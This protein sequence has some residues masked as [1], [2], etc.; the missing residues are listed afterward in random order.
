VIVLDDELGIKWATAGAPIASGWSRDDFR[1]ITSRELVHPDDMDR[2]VEAVG[3]WRNHQ[4]D[5]PTPPVTVRLR[6]IASAVVSLADA[7]SLRVV[8][9]GIETELERRVLRD[10]GC[11][12]GQGLLIS[13]PVGGEVFP[14]ALRRVEASMRR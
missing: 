1:R 14:E 10:L 13:A 12:L 9:E 8:A 6:A 11:H 7:M 5:E 3:A 2:L 4:L